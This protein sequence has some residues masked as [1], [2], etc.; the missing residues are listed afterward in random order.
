[1]KLHHEENLDFFREVIDKTAEHLHINSRF[2]EKDY[3]VTYALKNLSDSEFKNQLVFKGG[4]SLSKAFKLISR[5]S[6]D[7]DLAF[8][9]K[10]EITSNQIKRRIKQAEECITKDFEYIPNHPEESKGSQF[11][12]TYHKYPT[13]TKGAWGSISPHILLEINNFTIPEPKVSINI[14][15][16]I[17]DFLETEKHQNL[18]ANYGLCSF[19][20]QVLNV[21][22]TIAEK[23]MSLVRASSQDNSTINLRSKIRHIYDLC[24]IMRNDDYKQHF[25]KDGLLNMLNIVIEADKQQFNNESEQWLNSSLK[26][27]ILFAN[28]TQIWPDIKSEYIRLKEIAYG[29][30]PSEQEVF[31]MLEKV[32]IQLAKV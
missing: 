22:R 21:E 25:E 3:W 32:R 11:R 26:D 4:T 23:I 9:T 28:P 27:A 1:M 8:Y 7:I 30:I 19:P 17:S 16:L 31:N 13:I 5:F 14:Q 2:I 18:I 15:T 24:M 29:D 12:K 20:I 10:D 6:E